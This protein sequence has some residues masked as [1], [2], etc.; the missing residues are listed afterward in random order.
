M[1]S[2]SLTPLLQREARHG[3][4]GSNNNR[5]QTFSGIGNEK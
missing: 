3:L 2:S 4:V 1:I 5:A